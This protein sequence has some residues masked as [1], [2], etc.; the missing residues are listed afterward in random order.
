MY[1]HSVVL[2]VCVW[3]TSSLMICFFYRRVLRKCNKS[4]MKLLKQDIELLVH[5]MEK[6]G[7]DFDFHFW[8]TLLSDFFIIVRSPSGDLGCRLSASR[9]P[10]PLQ[11]MVPLYRLLSDFYS[12]LI[13]AKVKELLQLKLSSKNVITVVWFLLI[14]VSNQGWI[15]YYCCFLVFLCR[16]ET[17]QQRDFA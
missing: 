16:R 3:T 13:R 14:L 2:V 11:P 10:C 17:S 6:M 4:K 5:P 7:N 15:C 8:I 12:I 9:L 1:D